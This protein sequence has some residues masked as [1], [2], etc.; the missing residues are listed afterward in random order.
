MMRFCGGAR[1]GSSGRA[2]GAAF[3]RRYPVLALTA[4][5]VAAASPSPALAGTGSGEAHA[6]TVRPLTLVKVDDLDFGDI[7]PGATAGTVNIDPATGNRTVTG[8]AIAVGGSPQEAVFAGAARFGFLLTVAISPSPVLTRIG[9]GATMPTSLQVLGGT[10]LRLFPGTGP[11]I[12]RVG[13]T[14]NVA[15]NQMPGSYEGTFTL[16]V[17]YF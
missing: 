8:G 5:A 13:G 7:A 12:F 17:N 4:C 10:G 11:Q 14:L 6:V 1:P 9:G 16:T 15:A 2:A 3:Q